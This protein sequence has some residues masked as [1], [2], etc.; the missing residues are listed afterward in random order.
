MYWCCYSGWQHS[1]KRQFLIYIA[2]NLLFVFRSHTLTQTPTFPTNRDCS[3]FC[4]KEQRCQEHLASFALTVCSPTSHPPDFRFFGFIHSAF[5]LLIPSPF[6]DPPKMPIVHNRVD[7]AL[8]YYATTDWLPGFYARGLAIHIHSH[9]PATWPRFYHHSALVPVRRRKI[10]Q[11]YKN[12]FMCNA[13]MRRWH[14]KCHIHN[15]IS[16][17]RQRVQTDGRTEPFPFANRTGPFTE[18][19]NP[20]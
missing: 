7:L 16:S 2:T 5:F 3:T 20:I 14:V 10:T 6:A 19:S 4:L 12:C 8:W 15:I 13:I 1:E 9:T 18:K 11:H 17:R